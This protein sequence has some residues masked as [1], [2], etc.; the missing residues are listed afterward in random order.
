MTVTI[1]FDSLQISSL[2]TSHSLMMSPRVCAWRAR[3]QCSW[4]R[5][6]T[7]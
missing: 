5:V 4:P 3:I 1:A 6:R 2:Q 7:N